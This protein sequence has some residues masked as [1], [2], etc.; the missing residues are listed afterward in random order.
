MQTEAATLIAVLAAPIAVLAGVAALA[1]GLVAR[2]GRQRLVRGRVELDRETEVLQEEL[3]A[4]RETLERLRATAAAM[5]V[6]GREAD[7][8]LASMAD[9]LAK[10]RATI[11]G[12]GRGRLAPAV[13]AVH[14]ASALARVALLWRMPAR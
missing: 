8:R 5:T 11:E 6:R 9:E 3:T 1:V 7:M 14:L 4:T 2:R 13:R 10:G 12:I